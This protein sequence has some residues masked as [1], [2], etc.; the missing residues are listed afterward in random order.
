VLLS[1]ILAAAAMAMSSV[2]VVTN[3]LRL[4]CFTA[5]ADA[6]AILHQRGGSIMDIIVAVGQAL[7]EAFQFRRADIRCYNGKRYDT[8]Y[9]ACVRFAPPL[10]YR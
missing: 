2:S 8:T 7:R 1:P 10:L 3:A 6:H 9:A 5:P 4:R